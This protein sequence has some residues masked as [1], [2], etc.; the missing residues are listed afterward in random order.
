LQ[1]GFEKLGG[2]A[3]KELEKLDELKN[4]IVEMLEEVKEK[5]LKNFIFKLDGK[6]ASGNCQVS[7]F[8]GRGTEGGGET[9]H[10]SPG[11]PHTTGCRFQPRRSRMSPHS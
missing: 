8:P 10:R 4:K 5:Q 7:S 2:I 9:S 3:N 6:S 11:P 1:K